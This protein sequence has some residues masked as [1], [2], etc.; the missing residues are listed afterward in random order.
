[1][2]NYHPHFS[3]IP[4]IFRIYPPHFSIIS[5]IFRI[6][7]PNCSI[8]AHIFSNYPRHFL[9][10]PPHFSI[11]PNFFVLTSTFFQIILHIFRIIS[12]IL[13]LSPTI[14]PHIAVDFAEILLWEQISLINRNCGGSL[15]KMWRITC[16][17]VWDN[18]YECLDLSW[19][20]MRIIIAGANCWYKFGGIILGDNSKRKL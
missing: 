18:C 10:Y 5:H 11:I 12:P 9:I 13:M 14:F 16:K 7:P 1:M 19:G 17:I 6:Y 20:K 4:H 15:L 8:I 2:F 3:I